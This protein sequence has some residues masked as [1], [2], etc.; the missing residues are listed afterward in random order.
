M[1]FLMS[2]AQFTSHVVIEVRDEEISVCIDYSVS[3]SY[4]PGTLE[5][6]PEYPEVEVVRIYH[7]RNKDKDL[8]YSDVFGSDS[9]LL[10]F[11]TWE[12]EALEDAD[13]QVFDEP[14]ESCDVPDYWEP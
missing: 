13:N 9:G 5:D 7:A 8:A 4:M 6:P 10:D 3:G 2:Y 12:S 14:D 1:M 11:H